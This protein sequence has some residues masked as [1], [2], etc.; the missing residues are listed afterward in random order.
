MPEANGTSRSVS[1]VLR[2]QRS[3]VWL[4][5][6]F[7]VLICLRGVSLLFDHSL[8]S[9][10]GAM[11]TW[12]ALDNFA[13]GAKLGEAFQ[14]YLG[15]TMILALLPMFM[16]FGETLW[17]STFAAYVMVLAGSIVAAYAIVWML[18]PVPRK[19]RWM[20]A[21]LLL[22]IFY[23]AG[24]AVV[25][26][27]GLPYPATFDPG[28]SLRPLR[29]ALAFLVL[30]VFVWALRR[31]LEKET[32]V[33]AL[34]FGLVAGVGLLWSND[35]GIP[36]VVASGIGLTIA[37]L[38]RLGL[39]LK[40]L[41]AFALGVLASAFSMA[42]LVTHADPSGWLRYNFID[43]AGDQFWYFGPWDRESRILGIADL[44]QIFL[45]GE[46]LST[47][48]LIVLTACVIIATIRRARGQGTPIRTSAFVFVGASVFGTA[49]IPQIGGHIGS[50]YN[51]MTFVL[52]M[53]APLIMFQG[54]LFTLAKPMLR[55]PSPRVVPVTA[56]L[57]AITIIALETVGLVTTV[58]QTDRTVYSEE[59]GFY[60]SP[61]MS[62]DLAAMK[63]LSE[64]MEERGFAEDRRI[65]KLLSGIL[66]ALRLLSGVRRRVS[67][68]CF[69]NVKVLMR[70]RAQPY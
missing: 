20:F 52:G 56:G 19:Q 8:N 46:L 47:L 9:I 4:G 5:L 36:L 64:A 68:R 41:L 13:D 60:V 42:M 59:L 49:L 30:P 22:F 40:A 67:L 51:A 62:E 48:S 63:R 28:V 17:A 11:Q 70:A 43:V 29:G 12:F 55:R 7:A 1:A 65:A 25:S 37:L 45:Q 24:S 6:L 34:W 38:Q 2:E 18:R 50:E 66:T 44:P 69:L 21:I 3:W 57:A 32:S 54:N 10:D 53:C 14:S 33:P 23:Y 15:I 26:L 16:A 39:L 35:A 27:T 61:E 31:I 58:Q